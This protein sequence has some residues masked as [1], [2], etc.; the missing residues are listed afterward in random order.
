MYRLVGMG[1]V[2]VV[3]AFLAGGLTQSLVE[4]GYSPYATWQPGYSHTDSSC[5]NIVDPIGTVFTNGSGATSH[6][7]DHAKLTSHGG[8]EER[9]GGQ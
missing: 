6:V 3:L 4:A 1:M 5:N 2:T 7:Y 8:W 9:A